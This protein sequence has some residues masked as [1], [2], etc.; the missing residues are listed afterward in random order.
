MSRR[1]SAGSWSTGPHHPPAQRP[2]AT[3]SGGTTTNYDARGKVTTRET[4]ESSGITPQLYLIAIG[5]NGSVT[6]S[7]HTDSDI[8]EVCNHNVGE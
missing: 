4:I 6:A 7:R 8:K 5:S 3:D 2:V 1:T